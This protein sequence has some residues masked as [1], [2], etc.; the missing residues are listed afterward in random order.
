M[1]ALMY[2]AQPDLRPPTAEESQIAGELSRKLEH[3][4]SE[5][6]SP[7]GASPPPAA[8]VTIEIAGRA[9]E[10]LELPAS[11]LALVQTI[12]REMAQGNAVTLT[13]VHAELTTHQAAAFLNVSRPYLIKLLEAGKIP[14]RMV[15]THRRIKL[16]DLQ[17]YR[18][19]SDA[20]RRRALEELAR[21]TQEL[22]EDD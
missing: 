4:V 19:E 12:L 3:V 10:T 18:A 1:S 8:K 15:G 20:E 7:G 9:I 13:P 5:A 16:V 17:E 14:Y 2:A 22:G 6:A 11:V 21:M